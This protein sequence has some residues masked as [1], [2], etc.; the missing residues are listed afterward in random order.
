VFP[1]KDKEGTD[2]YPML[3]SVIFNSLPYT[4]HLCWYLMGNWEK[5]SQSLTISLYLLLTLS[6]IPINSFHVGQRC[7]QRVIYILS[8]TYLPLLNSA[9]LCWALS[10]AFPSQGPIKHPGQWALTPGRNPK[11]SP[12]SPLLPFLLHSLQSREIIC[13]QGIFTGIFLFQRNYCH[14]GVTVWRIS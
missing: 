2:V 13:E 12:F 14:G 8:G 7:Q 10:G 6:A 9:P 1:F 4:W 11:Y 5:A 3:Y